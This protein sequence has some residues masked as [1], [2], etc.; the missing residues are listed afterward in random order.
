M[1]GGIFDLCSVLMAAK[2]SPPMLVLLMLAESTL[3]RHAAGMLAIHVPACVFR[4]I[5]RS[6]HVCAHVRDFCMASL[7]CT[8]QAAR[9]RGAITYRTISSMV[10][11]QAMEVEDRGTALAKAWEKDADVRRRIAAGKLVTRLHKV[12]CMYMCM[13]A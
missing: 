5:S 4:N 6:A 13:L 3:M 9:A 1:P 8:E 7:M 11:G 2:V 12:I 10:S